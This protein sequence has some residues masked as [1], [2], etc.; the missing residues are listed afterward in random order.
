MRNLINAIFAASSS[1]CFFDP[2]IPT[3]SFL[4]LK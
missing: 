1:A 4:F 3:A 2:P